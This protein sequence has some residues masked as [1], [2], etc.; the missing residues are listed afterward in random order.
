MPMPLARRSVGYT[1]GVNAYKAP[2]VPSNEKLIN[3]VEPITTAGD[4]PRLYNMHPTALRIR[5]PTSVG[6]RPQRS[7]P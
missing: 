1:S 5:K 2:H 4:V 3:K 7:T 6:L